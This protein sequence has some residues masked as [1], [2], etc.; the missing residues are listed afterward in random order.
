M[1]GTQPLGGLRPETGRRRRR[2]REA[3]GGALDE[4][5]ELGDQG[6]RL[7]LQR[8]FLIVGLADRL[9][10]EVARLQRVVERLPVVFLRD[11]VVVLLQRALG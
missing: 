2:S 6:L 10:S 9:V 1:R 8:S 7:F 4:P 5:I 3:S 11:G